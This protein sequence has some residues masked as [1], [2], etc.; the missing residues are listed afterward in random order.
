[1]PRI[2]PTQFNYN[3]KEGMRLRS[4]KVINCINNIPFYTDFCNMTSG[5]NLDSNPQFGYCTKCFTLFSLFDFCEKYHK[6]LRGEE[7]NIY[8]KTSVFL[9]IYNVIRSKL[10]EFINVIDTEGLI[11]SCEEQDYIFDGAIYQN[12]CHMLDLS[13]EEEYS[14]MANY[15]GYGR[16]REKYRIYHKNFFEYYITDDGLEVIGR[17]FHRVREELAHWLKYFKH[18]HQSVIIDAKKILA[19]HERVK[20]NADCIGEILSFL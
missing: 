7:R 8:G 16:E 2:T 19:T 9:D 14:K 6:E 1:M 3:R 13:E 17:N 4:G 10:E 20:I 5:Y 11:C 15:T 12:I 18:A